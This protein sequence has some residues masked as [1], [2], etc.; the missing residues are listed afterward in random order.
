MVLEAGSLRSGCSHGQKRAL[1]Q[2]ANFSSYPYIL[3]GARELGG[4]SFI[5]ALIS[6]V[7]A[8]SSSPNHLLKALPSNTMTLDVQIPTCEFGGGLKHSVHNRSLHRADD[9]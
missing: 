3:E 1:F 9:N 2:V 5:R 4:I 8:P 7:R 6:F